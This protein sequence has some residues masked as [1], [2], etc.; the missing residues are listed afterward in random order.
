VKTNTQIKAKVEIG[1]VLSLNQNIACVRM[2]S[3]NERPGVNHTVLVLDCSGSMA[4]YIEDVSNDS[5]KYVAE[6]PKKDYV[7]VIVFSGHRDSKLIA[8]PVQCTESG[9]KLV[10]AAIQ[11]EVRVMSTTVFSEPLALTLT[12]A[13]K[14]LEKNVMHN[15]V[16]FTDG[17]A[18]PDLWTREE[19]QRKSLNIAHELRKF[20]AV[21]S[22]V[23][24]GVYYDS[25][26]INL[27]MAAADNT[28]VF[29]HISEIED[30]GPAMQT[31]LNAFELTTPASFDLIFTPSEGKAGRVFKTT[32]EVALVGEYGMVAT[33]GFYNGEVAFFVELTKECAHLKVEGLLD[34]ESVKLDL[35]ADEL[36]TQSAEE[37][38]RLKGAHAFLTGDRKTAAEL[39]RN[40][41]DTLMADKA[42]SAYTDREQ[43]EASDTFRQYFRN[44]KFIGAG[45]KPEGQNHCVL[46]VLRTLIEDTG[47][48]VFLGKGA[49]KRSGELTHDPRVIESP[50]GRTL[51][52]VGYVSKDDRFNFSVKCL[53]D[54]KVLPEN[55][56]GQPVDMKE[57]HTYNIILDGNLH[58]PELEA[59]LTK[60]SFDEL[61]SAGVISAKDKYAPTKTHTINLRGM[62]MISSAW[63]NPTALGLVPL[64]KEKAELLAEQTALNAQCKATTPAS[65][66]KDDGIYRRNGKKVEGVPQEFYSADCVEIELPK[67]KAK[68]YDCSR[69]TF[70]QADERVKEVRQR[71]VVVRNIIRSVTFAM[72]KVDSQI[73]NWSM[74][75]KVKRSTKDKLE[76]TATFQNTLLRKIT[77]T[78]QFIC[79]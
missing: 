42:A 13:K 76:Q 24:Y 31:A 8:G 14:L 77:W 28:G 16:L 48:V 64:L 70:E 33:R 23:G 15:A 66:K 29:R 2:E 72:D 49:Y 19:E 6:F 22:V 3:P 63:A 65:L 20:G 17:C 7:S 73:I 56:Q 71:L 52:V 53:K 36:S 18:I 78:E 11:R 21:V 30:F 10:I 54:I 4:G 55:L 34:G 40:V 43:R 79:S 35:E 9:R 25:Q 62:K 45:L 58:T 37:Y 39:F 50:H 67:Y 61:Q 69:L 51:R 27:L 60:A 59:V 1:Y 41:N 74:A 44:K 32:P 47:N 26:F 12:T 68:S 5:Q 75:T 57:W 46:N 38:T